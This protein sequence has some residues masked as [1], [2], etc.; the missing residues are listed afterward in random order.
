MKGKIKNINIKSAKDIDACIREI[1]EIKLDRAR[2]SGMGDSADISSIE[3]ELV[4]MKDSISALN[5]INRLRYFA[6]PVT[7]IAAA[8]S[9]VAFASAA[10]ISA[11]TL[12]ISSWKADKERHNLLKQINQ[13]KKS[14]FIKRVEVSK[15]LLSRVNRIAVGG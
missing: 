12:G 6:I 7:A 14:K 15:D 1:K 4:S 10:G 11:I 8:F 3:T 2:V 5:A 13:L 9:P